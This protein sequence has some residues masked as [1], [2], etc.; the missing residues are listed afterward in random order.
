MSSVSKIAQ[1]R[2][3]ESANLPAFVRLRGSAWAKL[4][5]SFIVTLNF[6]AIKWGPERHDKL[7]RGDYYFAFR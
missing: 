3:T 4:V 5:R 1:G 6:S 2:P 7:E